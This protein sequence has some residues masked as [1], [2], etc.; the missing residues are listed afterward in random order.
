MDLVKRTRR[1]IRKLQPLRR[2]PF[3]IIYSYMQYRVILSILTQQCQNP[4][5]DRQVIL[6][7]F[8]YSDNKKKG[9]ASEH[10]EQLSRLK[11]KDP[12]FFKF[13]QQNDQTLLNFDDT[14]SSEDEDE[15]KYH[16]L[17]STLEVGQL[18]VCELISSLE[19]KMSS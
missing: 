9:K 13:L 2:E 17:P 8:L 6:C 12:E 16:R 1:K 19:Q 10:K 14:D 7:F 11:N 3:D 5:K 15:K 18:L 4:L